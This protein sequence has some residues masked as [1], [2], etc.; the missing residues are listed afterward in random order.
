[1]TATGERL[2]HTLERRL[3]QLWFRA[4]PTA[5]DRA[6][7][8][9]LAPL[10]A[11]VKRA[12]SRQRQ[13]IAQLPAPPVPLVVV[14]NLVVGG[15]GKTPA[16]IALANALTQRGWRVGLLARGYRAPR[17][18]A[19]L[20]PPDADALQDGDEPVL[21]A[22]ATGCPVAAGRA[23]ADALRVLMSSH[24]D[25]DVVLSDDGLQ[26]VSLPRTL[27]LAVFDARG[28]GNGRLLP[29][30]PLREPLEVA[31]EADAL[32]LN[33]TDQAPLAANAP[34]FRFDV[35]ATGLRRMSDGVRESC[36]T[37]A[38]RARG[39]R[40]VAV[41]GIAQPARFFATLKALGIDAQP[42]A[43]ADHAH[44]DA[45]LTTGIDAELIVMT[46]KDAVKCGSIDDTRCWSLEVG[47]RFNPGAVDWLEER[48]RG[49]P[50]V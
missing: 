26:H 31:R 49:H 29:A 3:E 42:R 11:I 16:T 2:R 21:L 8:A 7:R 12:A 17:T 45:S 10:S 40:V 9:L 46:D 19:R 25:L 15:A 48:L 5:G 39:K 41:A 34:C 27:E 44:I 50:I 43:L 30:G 20:V 33:G 36:E 38:E 37:F 14:G 1:M 35:L 18:H 47:A 6:L 23:R 13:A 22:R 4:P 24:P 32:L 28:A